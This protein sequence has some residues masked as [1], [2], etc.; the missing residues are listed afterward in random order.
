MNEFKSSQQVDFPGNIVF[1]ADCSNRREIALVRRHA[2]SL[3]PANKS[4]QLVV[5]PFRKPSRRS[6]HQ[7]SLKAIIK[8][9]EETFFV[10]LRWI[11]FSGNSQETARIS[12]SD[13]LRGKI[14]SPGS[15]LQLLSALRGSEENQFIQGPGATL[16][17]LKGNFEKYV[18]LNQENLDF[19]EF[20][21]RSALLALEKTERDIRGAR[22]RIPR[23]IEREVLNRPA[24]TSALQK[25]SESSGKSIERLNR[26]AKACLKEMAATPSPLGNDLAAA[27]GHFMYT[28]G[29][30]PHIDIDEGDIERIRQ[31]LKDQPVAFLFTHKSHIDGFLLLW[32]FHRYNLPPAHVFGGINM[33]L[34]GLGKLLRSSGAIFIRR[35]FKNDD[36]YKAVFKNYIDYLGDKRFPVMWA[37]EGTRSR[38]GKLMPPRYGLINY[39]ANAYARDGAQDLVLMPISICYDQVPEVADYDA[40]QAGA[41]KRPESAS[42]FMEYI[43]G[44]KL[45]HG[46]IHVRFGQGVPLSRHLD[47]QNYIVDYRTVQKLAFDLAV[48]VNRATPIT[49]TSLICYVMLENGHR[50]VNFKELSG[51]IIKLWQLG[52]ELKSLFSQ[53]LLS[54]DENKI[55]QALTQLC[56]TQVLDVIDDGIESVYM[57]P[58]N[59]ARKPAYYRN[60]MLH[61]FTTCAIAELALLGVRSQGDE[62]ETEFE[63]EVLRIR[64]LLKYEFFFEGTEEFLITTD[65]EMTIRAPEWKTLL[66]RGPDGV[67]ELLATLSPLLGPGTLRPFIE[68]YLVLA[69]AL[70]MEN[71]VEPADSKVLTNRALNLGKQRVLQQRIHCE[72]SVSANYFENAIKIAENH[73]LLQISPDI[74]ERRQAWLDDLREL[75]S[76]I[77]LLASLSESRR[78]SER[79]KMEGELV[80]F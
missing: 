78:L 20:I 22:Y 10:P 30:D 44:L 9:N 43:S 49:L 19:E 38:T 80:Y 66:R 70:R 71:L 29:F 74:A 8:A 28:R 41:T 13:L 37:M 5:R 45:P 53:E 39:V 48:D 27:L 54:I 26:Y 25:V 69:R 3:L 51:D 59:G 17:E 7:G 18:S 77:R 79:R 6:L 47:Q 63:A 72:E 21:L 36:V 76:N 40:L 1:I 52:N 57:I 50:A 65:R 46:K 68:A 58:H 42:W 75:T 15:V 35:S 32:L 2:G 73:R 67:K 34:P 55:R 12:T 24:M 64:D 60:G 56:Q 11:L 62:T 16:A 23:L 61:F 31:L 4:F 33:S 14:S